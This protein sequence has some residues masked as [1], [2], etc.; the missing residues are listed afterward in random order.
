[1]EQFDNEVELIEYFIE[2]FNVLWKRR[3]LIIV[4]TILLALVA[5]IISFLIPPK[6]EIDA[7][8]HPGKL[9]VRSEKG[10]FTDA[11]A[12]DPKQLASQINQGSYNSLISAKL[13]LQPREFPKVRAENLRGTSLVRVSLKMRE[14]DKARTILNALFQHIKGELDQ[15]IDVEMESVSTQIAARENDI[16]IKS[17]DIQSKN[18]DIEK[19]QQEMISAGK[20]L[21][22]FEDRS[23]GLVDEI[24]KQQKATVELLLY[25]N[26][27]DLRSLIREKEQEI[28]S[29]KSEIEKINQEIAGIRSDIEPL[30]EIKL[31]IDYAQLVKEPTVSLRPVY[32]RKKVNVVLAGFLGFFCFSILALFLNYLEKRNI[33]LKTGS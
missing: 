13:N 5:G 28:K 27:E 26:R 12:M 7:I 6:W 30:I 1:M 21:N 4:P 29:L 14:T 33:R 18:I 8:I 23:R 3:W 17:L 24:E 2:Y 11:V 15:K 20:K 16:K 10:T 31:R 19:A 9:F 32:P 22:I 25:F